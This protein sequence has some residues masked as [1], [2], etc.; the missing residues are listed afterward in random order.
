[1]DMQGRNKPIWWPRQLG[2]MPLP[3]KKFKSMALTWCTLP[4]TS[5]AT[6]N[7]GKKHICTNTKDPSV[8]M[9]SYKIIYC[10][11]TKIHIN[12][13]KDNF[14]RKTPLNIGHIITT[15]NCYTS[16]TYYHHSVTAQVITN[17]INDTV[18]QRTNNTA[19]SWPHIT[20]TWWLN[21]TTLLFLNINH[22]T[23]VTATNIHNI[24]W[25]CSGRYQLYTEAL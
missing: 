8:V 11:Y 14:L 3:L 17:M 21:N 22:Y 5:P 23:A 19:S 7:G 15:Y 4:G 18:I 20:S 10:V 12:S 24:Q 6:W 13:Y 25:S 9:Y 2:L 1:M 16:C